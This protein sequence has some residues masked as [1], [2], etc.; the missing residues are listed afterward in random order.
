MS[1]KYTK[2]SEYWN[3][4]SSGNQDSSQPL[5]NL[6]HGDQSSEPNFVGEPFYTHETRASDSDRNGGQLDTTLRRNLAYVGPKIYKY[7]NIREGILLMVI[8]FAMLLSFARKLM[9]MLLF[10]E[11]L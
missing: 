3:K 5:E 7:G 10:L 2:K 6:I 4:L 8:I 11:M 9:Q 1:R